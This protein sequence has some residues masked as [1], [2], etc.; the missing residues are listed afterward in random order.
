MP[1]LRHHS[2]AARRLRRMACESIFEG[3]FTSMMVLRPSAYSTKKVR[4]VFTLASVGVDPAY[5]YAVTLLPLDH[6]DVRL[7]SG[8]HSPLHIALVGFVAIWAF[9][10]RLVDASLT[11]WH[12]SPS[13]PPARGFLTNGFFDLG[14]HSPSRFQAKVLRPVPRMLRRETS[15]EYV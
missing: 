1:R 10:R 2:S 15:F 7:Q 9:G 8:H 5:G 12:T 6:L 4:A 3:S 11:N 13:P 14:Q